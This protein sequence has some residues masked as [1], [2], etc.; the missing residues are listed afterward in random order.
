MLLVNDNV[1]FYG[2]IVKKLIAESKKK[3][4]LLSLVQRVT[5]PELLHMEPF[6]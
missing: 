2:K 3:R 6:S 5:N 4:K 1:K